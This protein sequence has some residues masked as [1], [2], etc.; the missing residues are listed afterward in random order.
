MTTGG[1][2][3]ADD[4]RHLTHAARANGQEAWLKARGVPFKREGTK[5]IV[6]WTHVQAWIEG[7]P[8]VASKEPDL[9]MVT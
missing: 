6:L 2:L 4:L 5:L 1:F 3:D 7:R 9:S 8:V